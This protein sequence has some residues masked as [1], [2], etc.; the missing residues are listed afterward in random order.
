M[1]KAQGDRQKASTTWENAGL[2]L[3]N[4]NNTPINYLFKLRF[5]LLISLKV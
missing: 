4:A 3:L 5:F 1:K 2:S